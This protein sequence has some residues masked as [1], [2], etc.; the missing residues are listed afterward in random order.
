[1]TQNTSRQALVVI[2]VQNEYF[3]GGRWTLAGMDAA[4]ENVTRLLTAALAR[5]RRQTASF[6]LEF[7]EGKLRCRYASV[8]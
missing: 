2:D 3:P 6:L 7:S 1:M 4:A 8:G 5:S